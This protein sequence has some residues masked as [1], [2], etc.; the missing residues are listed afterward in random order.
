[1]QRDDFVPSRADEVS[2][3]GSMR[4]FEPSDNRGPRGGGFRDGPGGG[5]REDR[6]V[7]DA[8]MVDD[9]GTAKKFVPSEDRGGRDGPRRGPMFD[10]GPSRADEEDSWGRGREFQ[11]S[12]SGPRGTSGGRPDRGPAGP[13]GPADTEDR[14]GKRS[15]PSAED[16]PAPAANG[17][18]Q[19][20]R[21]NLAPRTA[22]V[23]GAEAADAKPKSNNP[24]GAARP[25]E[26]VL[27]EQGKDPVKETLKLEHEETKR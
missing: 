2:D 9:W 3:W 22:P 7:S 17:A 16:K 13:A 6:P 8:D 14:W 4:K 12:N 1:M 15:L 23:E 21:L 5:P 10:R 26:E 20:P 27:R 18:G 24:F 25:R 11:P 19:R